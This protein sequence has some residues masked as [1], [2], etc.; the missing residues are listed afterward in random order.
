MN[1]HIGYNDEPL[2]PLTGKPRPD[3]A[4][5]VTAAAR[6]YQFTPD[7]RTVQS[8]NID[9][10]GSI[11]TYVMCEFNG[12]ADAPEPTMLAFGRVP[13]AGEWVWHAE[14]WWSVYRVLWSDG[15]AK[16]ILSY[17]A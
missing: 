10:L 9:A 8:D 3:Y 5:A 2:D 4:G 1:V 7:W 16:L 13:A 14:A 17:V 12:R 11:A 15:K 6:T